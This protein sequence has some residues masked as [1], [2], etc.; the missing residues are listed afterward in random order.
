M[1]LPLHS[2]SFRCLTYPPQTISASC[3]AHSLHSHAVSSR[4]PTHKLTTGSASQFESRSYSLKMA[5]AAL[6]K[7]LDE[8][9]AEQRQKETTKREVNSSDRLN[10]LG[11]A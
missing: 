2:S 6:S 1:Y 11:R 3:S 7:S 5:E 10:V 9:I 4:S 8:I